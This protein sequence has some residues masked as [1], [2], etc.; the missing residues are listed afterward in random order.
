MARPRCCA[1]P[2]SLSKM[3]RKC[4]EGTGGEQEGL[5][6]GSAEHRSH[7]GLVA[8]RELGPVLSP[9]P[10]RHSRYFDRCPETF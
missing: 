3:G 1:M 10:G 2:G 9:G 8:A 7:P 5:G 4:Q 6:L